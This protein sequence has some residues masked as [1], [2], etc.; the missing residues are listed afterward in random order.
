[1][2]V[3]A[4]F[5][6]DT[7]AKVAAA[8]LDDAFTNE[9]IEATCMCK[10]VGTG[11]AVDAVSA[12]RKLMGSRAIQADAWLG[13]NSFVCNATCAAE[14]DNTV[15]E[16]KIVQDIVRGRTSKF[17]AAMMGRIVGTV[18]GRTAAYSYL[19]LFAKAMWQGKAAIND[20]QLLRDL[21]WSRLHMR[22]IDVWLSGGV[23]NDVNWLDSY[24]KLMM[25]F[26]VPITM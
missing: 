26:P 1:L 21:A 2:A 19:T 10:F 23:A 15:M 4:A 12:I 17:P 13:E 5:I 3:V 9:L 20:G 18:H 7:R 16:L 11:F 22:V 14:G 6:G 25:V 8:I 24:A